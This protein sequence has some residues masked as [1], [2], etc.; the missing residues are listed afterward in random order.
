MS[1][2]HARPEPDLGALPSL[3]ERLVLMRELRGSSP[4]EVATAIGVSKVAL[5]KWEN[6]RSFPRADKL[7]RLASHFGVPVA[8]FERPV[9]EPPE[10]LHGISFGQRLAALRKQRHLTLASLGSLIGVSHVPIWRWENG[11]GYP[12]QEKLSR[13]ANAL[14]IPTVVLTDGE[15]GDLIEETIVYEEQLGLAIVKAKEEIARVAGLPPSAITI[16]VNRRRS[17]PKGVKP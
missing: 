7:Q 14:Q 5:W 13:L 15:G 11:R 2:A 6:N 16:S 8:L 10:P 9:R 3:G 1:D 12:D 17:G 4:K